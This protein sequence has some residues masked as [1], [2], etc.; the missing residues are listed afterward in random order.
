MWTVLALGQTSAASIENTTKP[1]MPTQHE[2]T[3]NILDTKKEFIKIKDG[4]LAPGE[5]NMATDRSNST[6]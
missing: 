2:Q 1:K 4:G 6:Q 5:Q 3:F